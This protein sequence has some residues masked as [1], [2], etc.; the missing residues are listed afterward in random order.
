M[1]DYNDS[2]INSIGVQ[3]QDGREM[4]WMDPHALYRAHDQTVELSFEPKL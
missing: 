2:F 4:D 1:A 3:P